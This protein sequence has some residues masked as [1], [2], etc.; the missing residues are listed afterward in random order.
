[1]MQF[2]TFAAVLALSLSVVL[3]TDQACTESIFFFPTVAEKRYTQLI[4]HTS[5][6]TYFTTAVSW[7]RD[8]IVY[9]EVRPIQ[10]TQTQSS[11]D[12]KGAAPKLPPKGW[13]KPAAPKTTQPIG[14]GAPPKA[15]ITPLP[16]G[17]GQQSA[18]NGWGQ[19]Q[20]PNGWGQNWGRNV[21]VEGDAAAPAASCV[22]S[23]IVYP[24]VTTAY[25][26]SVR[27]SSVVATRAQIY[28]E[29]YWIETS[30][31]SSLVPTT[32]VSTRKRC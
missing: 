23:I 9:G 16:N 4:P 6:K 30:V 15:Q 10:A 11:G 8:P 3:A 22:K 31:R 25:L 32:V 19:Q 13:P 17:W 7:I 28:T 29:T 24:T 1:M 21:E 26:T 5:V 27:S 14:W 18:P 2:S 12:C 20:A